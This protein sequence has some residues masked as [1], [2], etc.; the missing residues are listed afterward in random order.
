MQSDNKRVT[1]LSLTRDTLSR[2]SLRWQENN[3]RAAD[4]CIAFEFTPDS[5]Q[6]ERLAR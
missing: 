5:L 6:A 3:A 4:P 2:S 1:R